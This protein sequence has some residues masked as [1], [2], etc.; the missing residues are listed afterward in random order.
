MHV[1]QFVKVFFSYS[2]NLWGC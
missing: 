1:K 2:N